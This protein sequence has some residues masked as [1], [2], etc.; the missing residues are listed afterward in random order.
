MGFCMELQYLDCQLY[1]PLHERDAKDR[2]KRLFAV[3]PNQIFFPY[4]SLP[5][6]PC[7]LTATEIKERA[8]SLDALR[9]LMREWSTA[10]REIK[11]IAPLDADKSESILEDAEK[12]LVKFYTQQF[13]E[14]SGRAAVVPLQFPVAT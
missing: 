3:F 5:N 6:K 9:I 2:A 11:E 13:F 14:A 12:S 10:S 4:P 8:T 7:G 1:V